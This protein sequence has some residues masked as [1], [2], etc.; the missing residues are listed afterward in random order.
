M[1]NVNIFV[2][3]VI[4][5]EFY[6]LQCVTQHEQTH[7]FSCRFAVVLHC[8]G[9]TVV[10]SVVEIAGGLLTVKESITSSSVAGDSLTNVLVQH[11]AKEFYT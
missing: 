11:F 2:F 1:Q 7:L 6:H 9:T 5:K 10:A 3:S 8:G 4:I